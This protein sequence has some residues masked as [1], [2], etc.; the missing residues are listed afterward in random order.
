MDGKVQVS[1]DVTNTGDVAGEE[2]VQFYIRDHFASAVRPIKELKGFE[3][4]L[5]QPGE[6][7]TVNFEVDAETLAYY[8]ADNQFKAEPGMFTFMVR[9]HSAD[10]ISTDFE[11]K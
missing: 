2:V 5:L 4:I 7:K 1:I 10:L 11:L 8:A 3:K 6:T 9:G